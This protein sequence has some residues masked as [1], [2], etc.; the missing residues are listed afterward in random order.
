MLKSL[1]LPL[2]R[3][4]SSFSIIKCLCDVASTSTRASIIKRT[5][6]LTSVSASM[7]VWLIWS[8]LVIL[9][10]LP[11]RFVSPWWVS[12]ISITIN[13]YYWHKV[14]NLSSDTVILFKSCPSAYSLASQKSHLSCPV[15]LSTC[16]VLATILPS[17]NTLK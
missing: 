4:A 5:V 16:Q 1:Y 9:S 12:L 17:N 8:S 15:S 14:I 11:V 10:V 7:N 3:I 13:Y 6:S 2:K